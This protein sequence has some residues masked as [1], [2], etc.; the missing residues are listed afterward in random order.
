MDSAN[1]IVL[2]LLANQTNL[3]DGRLRNKR[4]L[5]VKLE[6]LGYDLVYGVIATGRQVEYKR[7]AALLKFPEASAEDRKVYI[8]IK[9]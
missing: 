7:T 8:L 3:F 6:G 2:T 1:Q 5:K 4:L 9:T